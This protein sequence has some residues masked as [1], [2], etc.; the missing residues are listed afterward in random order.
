M[1]K[2]GKGVSGMK[3]VCQAA[4]LAVMVHLLY[5]LVTLTVGYVKTMLF[6]PNIEALWA[7]DQALQQ[8]VSVSPIGYTVSLLATAWLFWCLLALYRKFTSKPIW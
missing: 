1:L 4:A 8:G 6:Q 7:N 2:Y 5:W 3:L